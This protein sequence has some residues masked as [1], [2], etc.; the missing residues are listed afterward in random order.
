MIVIQDVLINDEI[1]E[2]K[3]VCNLNACK[4]ACCW[5]GD[6]GAPTNV[7]E[8][9]QIQAYNEVIA[10]LLPEKNQKLLAENGGF[11]YYE[12][13]EINGTT[14]LPDGSCVYLAKDELGIAS[15]SIEKAHKLGL[16]PVNKPISC[17]LYPIRVEKNLYTNF[18]AWNYDEWDICSAACSLGDSL[19]VPVYQFLKE[20]IIRSKGED[21]YDELAAV[22]ERNG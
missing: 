17:H 10:S 19:Q 20:A 15:C 7:E 8:L 3:F 6:F 5:E 4:G 9:T 11:T 21:F 18:E 2:K 12:E 22:A 1:I 16:I 13:A 14:L